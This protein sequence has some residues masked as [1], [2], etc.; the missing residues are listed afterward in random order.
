MMRAC[1][2]RM[3]HARC[4]SKPQEYC[5]ARFGRSGRRSTHRCGFQ[6]ALAA[7]DALVTAFDLTGFAEADATADIASGTSEYIIDMAPIRKARAKAEHEAAE[8]AAAEAA[9][10][11]AAISA[12]RHGAVRV[13]TAPHQLAQQDA[14]S[15][16]H[17]GY[18]PDC[19]MHT[20]LVAH[21]SNS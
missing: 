9:A 10:A 19:P 16:P 15:T 18:V 21:I 12:G 11:D 2:N 20:G 4:C 3:L 13:P 7:L 8:A 1:K 6:E 5:H 17:S 14:Q